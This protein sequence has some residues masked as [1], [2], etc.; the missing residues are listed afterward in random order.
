MTDTEMR[1]RL[2]GMINGYCVTQAVYAAATLGIADLLK[3]GPRTVDDLAA[4]T[5]TRPDRLYRLLRALA[6]VDL[7]AETEQGAFTLT[8]MAEL[9]RSDAPFSAR[10]FA[11]MAGEEHY[12]TWGRLLE[13]LKSDDN[14]F[15]VLYGK[16]IFEFLAENPEQGRIFDDAM[17]GIHGQ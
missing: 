11:R 10:S 16:P 9:L 8:P 4:A 14:A 6:S 7:F 1:A 5:G 15:E 17:T 12:V 13:A 2:A 3:E